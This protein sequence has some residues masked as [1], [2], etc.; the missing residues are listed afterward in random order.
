M[1]CSEC[2]SGGK[3]KQAWVNGGRSHDSLKVANALTVKVMEIPRSVAPSEIWLRDYL[4]NIYALLFWFLGFGFWLAMSN[5][6]WLVT[7]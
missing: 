3:F 7:Q 1:Q 6:G 2:E 4:E 5:V